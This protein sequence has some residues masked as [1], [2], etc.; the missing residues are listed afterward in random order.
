MVSDDPLYGGRRMIVS[1]LRRFRRLALAAALS[2][3]LVGIA[4]AVLAQSVPRLDS[5]I[6]DQT[7]VLASDKAEIEAALQTLF[8]RTRVQLYVLFVH[9]TDGVEIA[10]YAAAVGEQ[11]LGDTDALLVV[12]L[13]DR[14]DNISVG[15]GLRGA[16]SQV[17]IDRVRADVLEPGLADGDFGGAVVRTANAL[18]SVL[19]ATEPPPTGVPPTAVPPTIGPAVT[20]PPSE[21][22][23]G[24]NALAIV[25]LVLVTIGAA[26]V[27]LWI[28]G[29][30]RRLRNERLA[31]F[32]EAKTQEELGRQANR[33]LIG[34]DDAL[35]DAEQEL[36]FAEAEFGAEESQ[37]LRAAL[38][39]AKTELNAAFQIGQKLDDSIPEPPELRRNMIQ[40]IIERCQRAQKVVDAQAARL[41][42]LRDLERNAPQVLD[43]LAGDLDQAT[44]RLGGIEPIRTRLSAYAAA[45]VGTA[46][47]NFDAAQQKVDAARDKLDAGRA[48]LKDG[49]P[50]EAA[51]AAKAAEQAIA[52][53]GALLDGAGR[54]ADSL[55]ETAAKL[56]SEIPAAVADLEAARK[57]VAKGDAAGLA[58]S[59]ADAD[60]ALAEAKEAAAADPPDV[61]RA[62]RR[63]TEANNLADKLLESARAAEEQRQRAYQAASSA[64]TSA[65]T[66]LSRA[67]DYIAAYRRSQSIGR[68][69]RNRLAEGERELAAAQGLLDTDTAQALQHAQAASRLANEAY[70]FAQQVPPGYGPIDYGSVRPGTDL[71]SLVIGAI[72]GGM[73]SGGGGG[74]RGS[75]SSPGGVVRPGRSG[76]GFGGGR[77][78]SGGFGFGGFGS[79]GFG[80]GNIGG[81]GGFG[82][83][84]SSSGHW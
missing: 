68:M 74:R 6:T 66:S 71:G 25:G 75:G 32:N 19:G 82:G 46:I 1:S 73:F 45:S 50:A 54:L 38:A 70:G 2:L 48:S 16:V 81:G 29:R 47:G 65:E 8:E 28:V 26:I 60:A 24:S 57:V 22:A 77:S 36:G 15:S 7:G 42:E 51:T 12:A 4:G 53:A 43:R 41:A 67:R 61:M 21:P 52:D 56:K 27:T 40:E 44:K 78:S 9:S 58:Q 39:G 83:G 62:Y 64:I 84:R 31:A 49:K 55:D 35:R 14:T 20:P 30:M 37:V 76:S 33:L 23:L 13:D 11:N 72:L 63:A 69:A 59:L 79:G 80:G 17:D 10:D 18:V 3:T 34:T 5:A